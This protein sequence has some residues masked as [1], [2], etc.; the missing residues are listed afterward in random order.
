[1]LTPLKLPNDIDVV[2]LMDICIENQGLLVYN[3]QLRPCEA[4]AGR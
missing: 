4:G 2:F 1:M 3:N